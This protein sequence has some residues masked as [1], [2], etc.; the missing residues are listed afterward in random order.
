MGLQEILSLEANTESAMRSKRCSQL[1]LCYELMAEVTRDATVQDLAVSKVKLVSGLAAVENLALQDYSGRPAPEVGTLTKARTDLAVPPVDMQLESEL[2][3]CPEKWLKYYYLAALSYRE[4]NLNSCET[5]VTYLVDG[6]A[7]YPG[8]AV[9]TEVL[10]AFQ[11]GLPKP[12]EP[13]SEYTQS[14]NQFGAAYFLSVLGIGAGE[15]LICGLGTDASEAGVVLG[16]LLVGAVLGA[17]YG[18][19][20]RGRGWQLS[21]CIGLSII[22]IPGILLLGGVILA[23]VILLAVLSGG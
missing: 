13:E 21:T 4:K 22:G 8:N 5:A 2:L 15:G 12:A 11:A 23:G 20:V 1:V 17:I 3:K 6:L 14:L 16:M 10:G 9:M 18:A 7:K 19:L